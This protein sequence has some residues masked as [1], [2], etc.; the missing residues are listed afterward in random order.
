VSTWET[1]AAIAGGGV[2]STAL[3]W[4]R[5]RQ[6]VRAA[7][8]RDAVTTASQLNDMALEL[9]EPYRAE[10][11]ELKHRVK[12]VEDEV[13]TVRGLLREAATIL[14]DFIDER[15]SRGAPVPPMS[16]ELRD[17]IERTA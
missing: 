15:N 6:E 7:G 17:E 3:R 12:A 10:M 8:R 16:S 14:R 13:S 1:L 2:G 11:T 4:L 5:D 9:L